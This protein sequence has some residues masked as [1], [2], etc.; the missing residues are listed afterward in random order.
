[1]KTEADLKREIVA[2]LK[3]VGAWF[4]NPVRNGYGRRGVP[5]LVCCYRGRFLAI[6]VKASA[7]KKATVWQQREIAAIIEAGGRAI[8]AWTVDHVREEIEAID[9]EFTMPEL[10]DAL[11]RERGPVVEQLPD[12]SWR[13]A[14]LKWK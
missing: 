2:Y 6:E 7:E 8:V 4:D 1:M 9:R 13:R 3:S 14:P 11:A 5:D 10:M 12:G